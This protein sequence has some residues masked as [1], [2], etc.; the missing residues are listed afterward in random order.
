MNVE[1]WKRTIVA[2]LIRAGIVTMFAVAV[3]LTTGGVQLAAAESVLD[4]V[5][6]R[7]TL[8]VAGV[9]YRPLIM[10]RQLCERV[11]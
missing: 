5:K 9:V 3:W 7:G 11:A 6:A 4:E 10:R 8:R 2:R 1:L